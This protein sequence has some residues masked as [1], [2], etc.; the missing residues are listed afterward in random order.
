MLTREQVYN[1]LIW[2]NRNREDHPFSGWP[3][4]VIQNISDCGQDSNNDIS[5]A[6]AHAAYARQEDVDALLGMLKD[7]PR[8]LLQAGNVKTPGGLNVQRVTIYEFLLGAGDIELANWVVPFFSEI[9]SGEAERQRQLERYHPH[10]VSMMTQVPY[11]TQPIFDLLLDPANQTTIHA[12]VNA[13]LANDPKHQSALSDAI[14]QFRN[15]HLPT[16]P[17]IKPRMHFNY[18]THLALCQK[19]YHEETRMALHKASGGNDNMINLIW[20]KMISHLM[21][22]YPGIDRCIAAQGIAHIYQRDFSEAN[23]IK[24]SYQLTHHPIHFPTF[25]T[26]TEQGMLGVDFGISL[27]GSLDTTLQV[28][29]PAFYYTYQAK[30]IKVAEHLANHAASQQNQRARH[31]SL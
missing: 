21:N 6:L 26:I 28:W 3:T 1:L 12:D 17:L 16:Q 23:Q 10:L 25:G 30:H 4:H 2:R 20:L 7:N 11:D 18:A 24:R 13:L 31:F 9:P 19:L 27:Y 5:K 29:G 22:F 15:A 8:L 14:A